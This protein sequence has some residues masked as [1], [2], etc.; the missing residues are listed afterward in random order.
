MDY[1]NYVKQS[2]VQGLTGAWG[3]VQGAL[4]QSSAAGV[5]Y[6]G[7]RGVFQLSGGDNNGTYEYID[8]TT[9]SDGADFGD[10]IAGRNGRGAGVGFAGGETNRACYGGG[11]DEDDIFYV[12]VSTLGNATVFGTILRGTSSDR[13]GAAQ[14]SDG[15]WGYILGGNYSDD[16]EYVVIDTTS[17]S[18]TFGS[19]VNGQRT[20]FCASNTT[21]G[22][23]LG[24]F[25]QTTISHN[26][27]EKINL[28]ST[29]N[30]SDYGDLTAAY[31]Q[32]GTTFSKT[33][34]I[35]MGGKVTYGV[36]TSNNMDQKSFASSSNATNFGQLT[37]TVRI[38]GGASN[39]TRGICFAGITGTG[40]NNEIQKITVDTASNATD[41]GDTQGESYNLAGASGSPS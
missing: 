9:T 32:S 33:K 38:G 14:C 1:I 20:A 11:D 30:A 15:T 27:I 36:N 3:G 25:P 5:K 22:L 10:M 24:G 35:T 2:P 37:T 40:N 17:N 21:I 13:Y 4:G 19:L 26:V 29:G 34:A 6:Y 7:D 12:T 16:I 41:F 18:N 8:I 39:I 31:F 23:N 28:G